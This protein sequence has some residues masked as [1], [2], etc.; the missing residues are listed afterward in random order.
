TLLE[1]GI[2][3]F[4][5]KYRLARLGSAIQRAV[6]RAHERQGRREAESALRASE[7]QLQAAL[8]DTR[9]ARERLEA[10]VAA[11]T[12]ELRRQ[13]N[14]LL[15]L[16]DNLPFRAWL[17]DAD[18]RFLAVNRAQGLRYGRTPQQLV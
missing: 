17:K 10:E 16:I 8:R 3:D 4:V 5:L 15:A 11:R 9:A 2:D 6:A 12:A 18:G 14:Y 13:T 7:A 1:A